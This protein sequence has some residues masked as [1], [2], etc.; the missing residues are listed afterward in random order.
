LRALPPF[1]TR[2]SSDLVEALDECVEEGGLAGSD[3][4]GQHE[5]P[6][7]LLDAVHELGQRLAVSRRE[8]EEPRVGRR[9]ERSL[10]ELVKSQI[11][12]LR[13]STGPSQ[14]APRDRRRT[15]WSFPCA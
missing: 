3:L 8:V 7:A 1:P 6:A 4:P 11:H 10:F 2:R 12:R 5:E 13:P 9:I 15:N 14:D